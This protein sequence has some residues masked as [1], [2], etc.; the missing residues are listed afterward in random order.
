M[1]MSNL[2]EFDVCP[3]AVNMENS[4]FIEGFSYNQR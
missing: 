2:N 4:D 1:K 3:K